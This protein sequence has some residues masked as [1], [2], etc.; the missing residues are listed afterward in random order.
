[1]KTGTRGLAALARLYG[2]ET[3]FETIDGTRQKADGEALSLTLRALGAA[4]DDD[5]RGA[6]RALAARRAELDALGI[7][8]VHV[9]WNGDLREVRLRLDDT[10]AVRVLVHLRLESGDVVTQHAE[11]SPVPPRARGGWRATHR[12]AISRR[13]PVGYH[14]LSVETP[15][16]TLDSFIIAAP[17]RA[18]AP[19]D[20]R[21][22]GLFLPLYALCSGAS[23]GVG[24]YS[25]LKRMASWAGDA[26]AGFIST[27]PLLAAFLDAPFDPSPYSPASRL[28]W[29]ELFVDVTRVPGWTPADTQVE[30][31][32]RGCRTGRLVDYQRTAAL[33]RRELE[34]ALR[35]GLESTAIRDGLNRFEQSFPRVADYCAFRAVCDH[36]REGWPTW[37][38]RLRSGVLREGDYTADDY[39]YHLFAQWQ[40]DTQ[41][42][43]VA[44]ARQEGAAAL[45]LDMPL[46]VH[47]DS[48]DVWRFPDLFAGN[49]S[50]GAPPDPLFT[51]GQ[52]WG[53]RPLHP[54]RLRETRYAYLI[55]VFRHHLRHARMLRL[56]HVMSL[57][58]LFWVPQ[59][60]SAKQGV[61]VR[62]PEDELFAVLVM[63]SARHNAIVIGE[64]LGT[65]PPPVRKAMDR[66]CVQRM[67]VVQFEASPDQDP[68]VPTPPENVVASLNTHDMPTFAGFWR[69]SEIDDQL[70]LGLIDGEEHGRALER[71]ADLRQRL[72][73]Q[74]GAGGEVD[75]GLARQRL[76]ERLAASRARHVLVTLEDLWLEEEPQNVP[77]TSDERPNWKRRASR[78]IDEITSDAAIR[79]MLASID[80]R[81]TQAQ[82]SL[83]DTDG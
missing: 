5:G 43:D 78:S 74:L 83:T 19:H 17:S 48:Y 62:Y 72:S 11:A 39:L 67:H 38:D 25:D 55:E 53:F 22:W 23:W 26:G 3:S 30:D 35:N 47:P 32:I 14:E 77:G 57:Y 18:H 50:A 28:F 21:E 68:P 54:R 56:D 61:Y 81:R 6:R 64:D 65:V 51:G 2:V 59:G 44:A 10:E 70:D 13:L 34:R 63:E 20:A 82:Q 33:K 31:E 66:H 42:G 49:V 75:A 29:N 73:R 58:R 80:T 9:A 27:L 52:N 24:D 46:G 45:Y 36:R 16:Q 41:L 69:G 15:D 37:P 1:V 79:R 8:P 4:L 60:L 7:Q 76:L 40:A 12:I 71:R